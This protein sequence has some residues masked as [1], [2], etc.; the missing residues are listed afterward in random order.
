VRSQAPIEKSDKYTRHKDERT[1]LSDAP[2]ASVVLPK[3]HGK[4]SVKT[5]VVQILSGAPRA[6]SPRM[7]KSFVDRQYSPLTDMG[8]SEW[9]IILEELTCTSYIVKEEPTSDDDE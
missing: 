7:R 3:S 9:E 6:I 4:G 8:L 1:L 2:G 5:M